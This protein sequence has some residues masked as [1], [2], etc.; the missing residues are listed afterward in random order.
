MEEETYQVS[1]TKENQYVVKDLTKEQTVKVI[2]IKGE[3][4]EKG[5]TALSVT[6]GTT[7]S[8]EA[9]TSA[10]VTNAGTNTDL[11]LCTDYYKNINI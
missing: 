1:I 4:G 10:S 6:V 5:D 11:V 3:D 2:A 8:G 7:T 9:G